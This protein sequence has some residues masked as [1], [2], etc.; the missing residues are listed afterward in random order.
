MVRCRFTQFMPWD[1]PVR[2][3]PIRTICK[4]RSC[5]SAWTCNWMCARLWLSVASCEVRQKPKKVPLGLARNRKIFVLSYHKAG[6]AS[7]KCT[8]GVGKVWERV[9]ATFPERTTLDPDDCIPYLL[10]EDGGYVVAD[11]EAEERTEDDVQGSGGAGAKDKAGPGLLAFG[12]LAGKYLTHH[13]LADADKPMPGPV[14]DE[15]A[16]HFA[17]ILGLLGHQAQNTPRKRG[18]H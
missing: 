10:G 15:L 5:K 6:F 14:S 12:G 13:A 9:P 18:L 7:G 3:R 4:V 11:P 2:G 8:P 16:S 17:R 1:A